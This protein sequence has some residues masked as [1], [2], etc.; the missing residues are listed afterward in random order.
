M[1]SHWYPDVLVCN[2]RLP[3]Q[4]GYT[5]VHKLRGLQTD[6]DK[7]LFAIAV[8]TLLK[9]QDCLKLLSGNFQLESFQKYLPKPT[10]IYELVAAVAELARLQA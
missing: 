6:P 7:F 9:Q 8:T 3:G 2:V 10:D 4:D 1:T 5:L